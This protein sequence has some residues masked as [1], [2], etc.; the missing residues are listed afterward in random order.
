MYLDRN[1]IH[2]FQSLVCYSFDIFTHKIYFFSINNFIL[3][4]PLD[5]TLI[6]KLSLSNI[7]MLGFPY[8]FFILLMSSCDSTAYQVIA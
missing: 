3:F 1:K 4:F 8:A 6:E 7:S 2:D 5:F